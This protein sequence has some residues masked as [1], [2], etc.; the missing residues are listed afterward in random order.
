MGT[1]M[2]IV[3]T[4]T[5]SSAGGS[6]GSKTQDGLNPVGRKK[7]KRLKREELSTQ[8]VMKLATSM[9]ASAKSIERNSEVQTQRN[10]IMVF[11]GNIGEMD[12]AAR[13]ERDEYFTLM[14]KTHLAARTAA[15]KLTHAPKSLDN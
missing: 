5:G 15:A 14:R 4:T 10:G 3:A 8:V 2:A 9:E 1:A 7:A 6:A 11:S 12:A 13:A